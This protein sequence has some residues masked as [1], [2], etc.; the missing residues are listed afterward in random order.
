MKDIKVG[1]GL[2]NIKFGCSREE[3]KKLI[4]KPSEIDTY[5]A[6]G[7]EEG[8]LTESWH[9]DED[10]FSVSFDEEDNWKLTT[11][12]VSSPNFELNGKKIIGLSIEETLEQLANEDLGDNELDDLSD[13]HTNHKLISFI[14]SSLNLWFENDKLSEIQWGVLW[15]DEDTPIWPQ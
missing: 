2:G 4:G 5:N 6:S 14:S 15:Q 8:Y 13:E 11:I 1:I 9:Y 12:A 3:L 7:E 10:E